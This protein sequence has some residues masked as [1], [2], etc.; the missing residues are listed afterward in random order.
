MAAFKIM[1]PLYFAWLVA[2]LPAPVADV[3]PRAGTFISAPS[4]TTYDNTL[5][6][7]QKATPT[8]VP[9]RIGTLNIELETKAGNGL[10]FT[11]PLIQYT[12]LEI[13]SSSIDANYPEST[14]ARSSNIFVPISNDPPPPQIQSREDHPVNGVGIADMSKP[15]S[16]NKFY[17]NLFLDSQAQS[18]WTHPYSLRWIKGGSS[19]KSW[20]MG[21][22]HIE[23]NQYAFGEGDPAKN[24]VCPIGI[25]HF[26]F[27]AK[28]LGN[29]TRLT[30]DTLTAFSV[31]A[32]LRPWENAEPAIS[33]PMVQGQGFTTAI[34]KNSKPI[35]ESGVFF[36]SLTFVQTLEGSTPI[37]KY[38]L[39]LNDQSNWLMYAT[40]TGSA[41]QPP[42]KLEDS[43]RISGPDGYNGLI[44]I[45]KNN[46]AEAGEAI[47]D[48]SAG[49]Y[50]CGA[51]L[52]GSVDGSTGT[53]SISWKKGGLTDRTLVMFAL[54]HH[55][56][57]FDEGTKS[58][59]TP[60]QLQTTTKGIA[61][62][63]KA[64]KITMIE[65]GLPNTYGFLPWDEGNSK[66]IRQVAIDAI[67][68]AGSSEL[69]QNMEPQ[70]VLNS[71]YYSGKG[72]AKFASIIIA[73]NDIAKNTQL[74]ASGLVQLKKVFDV[75]VQNKQPFPLVYD[76]RWK[77]LVSSGSYATGDNGVDF[78][79]SLYND[80]HFHYGYFIYTAA[81]IGY[82]DPLWLTQGTNKAWVNSLLRDYANPSADDQVYAHVRAFDWY[83]GHSWA[84]G[85][86]ESG[87]GKDQE[88]TSED[89][90]ATYGMKMWG[91]IVGDPNMEARGNLQLAVQKRSFNSYFLMANDNKIQPQKFIGNKVTGILFENKID[92]TTYFGSNP[93]YIQGIH[94]IPLS[95]VSAYTR[96]SSF[97]KEEWDTYFS[98]GRADKV[99]GGWKGILYANYALIDPVKSYDFFSSSNFD[100]GGLDGGA[101]RTW[102]LALAA[103][104]GGSV[105]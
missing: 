91:R 30:T 43:S 23:A 88:S 2:A 103:G 80:H 44:Q 11:L 67:D 68:N 28:E 5:A 39:V 55:V 33:F 85:L 49:A 8:A 14:A 89:S 4:T 22:T 26:I 65:A 42:F 41:G 31:N 17:A 45:A 61:T 75:F 84:K 71:M 52:T 7:Y 100:V 81:V 87:D 62:A 40:P 60:V 37:H 51:E 10:P 29:G 13:V 82:L 97:V 101:S 38:R 86:F 18:V 64:D 16:T 3:L 58:V 76:T 105:A 15:I 53:Y 70:C 63:V 59:T 32:D 96:P 19:L 72:L 12:S 20:G 83:N 104:L 56:A 102:Y 34:Y 77:G 35:L 98:N 24:F 66:Q 90:F 74:A 79:N 95:P 1:A 92:H 6:Y 99:E 25:N 57:A 94:M 36:S 48:A 27:S 73:V 54:P 9:E 93:E 69:S 47:Y 21:V 46:N 50:A 78:G